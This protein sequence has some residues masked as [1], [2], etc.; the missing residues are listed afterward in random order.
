MTN[1]LISKIEKLCADKNIKLTKNRKIVAR[2]IAESKDHPDVE[3]VFRRV[4]KIAPNIG[5]ATIY[6]TV[7]TFEEIGVITK[8]DFGQGKAR[9]EEASE[10][11]HHDHLIDINSGAVV[12]FYNKEIEKLKEKIAVGLGYKLVGHRLELYGTPL[13]KKMKKNIKHK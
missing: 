12:E 4:S 7:R 1:E 11:D 9:Y 3:E 10:D 5:I 2:I 8:H 13:E 6:R